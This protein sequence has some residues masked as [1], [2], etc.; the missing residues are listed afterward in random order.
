MI[1]ARKYQS[2]IFNVTRRL[3]V[4]TVNVATRVLWSPVFLAAAVLGPLFLWCVVWLPEVAVIHYGINKGPDL[5]RL[6]YLRAIDDY[7]KTIAQI[8]AGLFVAFGALAT[9]RNIGTVRKGQI[10]DRFTKAIDQLGALD[11]A[12]NPRLEVRLGGIYSL[13]RVLCES[14]GDRQSIMDI[15]TAY[16]RHNASWREQ[17]HWE[18]PTP[19]REERLRADIQAVLTILGRHTP[20]VAAKTGSE[21]CRPSRRIPAWSKSGWSLIRWSTP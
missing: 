13:E 16:V 12:G 9:W 6:E 21:W 3:R 2:K 19:P 14:E 15:L 11:S 4:L 10:T 18:P 7:R 5:T 20:L 8:F 17:R 1:S